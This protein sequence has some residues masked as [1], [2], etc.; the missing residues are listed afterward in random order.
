MASFITGVSISQ[1]KNELVLINVFL[2]L[3]SDIKAAQ[4]GG[5]VAAPLRSVG[6]DSRR[7]SD[8]V[9]DAAHAGVT[10]WL[11]LNSF[12]VNPETN[13]LVCAGDTHSLQFRSSSDLLA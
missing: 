13:V 6:K 12:E 9:T 7:L 8:E 1:K 3:F 5:R 4:Q 2:S 10:D 11:G